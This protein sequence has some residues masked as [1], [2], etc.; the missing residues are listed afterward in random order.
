MGENSRGLA[1]RVGWVERSETQ[2]NPAKR[3]TN[4]E[5]GMSNDEIRISFDI[6]HSKFLVL[7]FDMLFLGGFRFATG[8]PCLIKQ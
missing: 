7:R 3:I 2:P 8:T 6:R 5:Q 1:E 4:I